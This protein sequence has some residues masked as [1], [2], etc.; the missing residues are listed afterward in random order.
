MEGGSCGGKNIALVQFLMWCRPC[1]VDVEREKLA[2]A[3]VPT[4]LFLHT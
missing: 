4:A 2:D 1:S 3:W